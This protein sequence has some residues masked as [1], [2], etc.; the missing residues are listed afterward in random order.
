[1]FSWQKWTF[2]LV[3][4]NILQLIYKDCYMTENLSGSKN[5]VHTYWWSASILNH[6]NH[7]AKVSPNCQER[8]FFQSGGYGIQLAKCLGVNWARGSTCINSVRGCQVHVTET[9][10]MGIVF[11][12]TEYWLLIDN[13][14]LSVSNLFGLLW[15]Y[16]CSGLNPTMC[17]WIIWT[18]RIFIRRFHRVRI[19]NVA[20]TFS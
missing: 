6:V 15:S 8:A 9:V 2:L 18:E 13:S 12:T 20:P 16:R 3:R 4:V 10:E 17:L 11:S 19:T 1:M 5:V 14:L 7:S